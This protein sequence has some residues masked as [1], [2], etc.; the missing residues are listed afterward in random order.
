MNNPRPLLPAAFHLTNSCIL[1]IFLAFWLDVFFNYFNLTGQSWISAV[2]IVPLRILMM[3][4][5]LATIPELASREHYLINRRRFI[6][7]ARQ[8][9]P[10]YAFMA[11][12]LVL[13]H[14]G[15][16]VGGLIPP[17]FEIYH[18]FA[19][20]DI[21]IGFFLLHTVFYGKY[22]EPMKLPGRRVRLSGSEAAT[23]LGIYGLK[24]F[25]F[26]L[27]YY[28]QNAVIE[29]PRFASLFIIYLD[30]LLLAYLAQA[31]VRTYPE[32]EA[33]YNPDKEIFFI[34]PLGG[35]IFYYISSMF[36][37]RHTPAFMVLRALTPEG[38]RF[39]EF[40]FK[41]WHPHYYAPNKLV[42]ITCFTSNCSDAYE[43]AQEFRRRG[44]TVVLGGPHVTYMPEE[45]LEFCDSVVLGEAESAWP[46]IIADYEAGAMKQIYRGHALDNCHE[47]IHA[48]LMKSPPAMVR[49]FL[50]TTR[51]CKFRCSF[52][53]VPNL[54]EG[55]VRTKSIDDLVQLLKRV[56]TEYREVT[57]ID[58]NIYSD[59]GYAREL[60]EAIKPL[61]MRWMTQC[62][63]DVAKNEQTL[64]LMREAGCQGLLIGFEISEG[65]FEKQ[66]GGKLS[67]ADNFRIYAQKIREQGIKIKAHFIFGFDSD[68]LRN[69][70]KFWRFCFSIHPV[71]T[72]ISVL[73]P[74]PGT[75]VHTDMLREDRITDLNWRN[76]GGH[77]LVFRHDHINNFVLRKGWPVIYFFFFST[78]SFLGHIYL[79][80][81][82]VAGVV[83]FM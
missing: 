32:L 61:K 69:L 57:F 6:K 40:S 21:L 33:E 1:L 15:L 18:A 55:K 66:Q 8:Y 28:Y 4:G 39:R 73:T 29:L 60:F 71:V 34:N 59:P 53:A 23:V 16:V 27:P 56:R 45:A 41:T 42:A 67:M 65:S 51:G 62:T 25:C 50:E 30:F 19:H 35:G 79:A 49:D 52:C 3:A 26:Y 75:K 13:I 20:F 70:I 63:I 10:L 47:L 68:R 46:E 17:R 48:E 82:F 9:W 80:V 43:I 12:I 77:T 76:Y 22:L 2:L 7:N 36:M 14:M 31:M 38:Y 44:S 74:F 64:K 24:L 78:T 58:N 81:I 11:A 83:H 5:I 54:S 37:P 72:V